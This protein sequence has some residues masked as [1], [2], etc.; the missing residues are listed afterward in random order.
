M[1]EGSRA[2]RHKLADKRLDLDLFIHLFCFISLLLIGADTWGVELLG[3]NFRV[4][5]I[6]LCIFALLLVFKGAY[7]LTAYG[8]ILAF[9]FF[10]FLSTLFAVSIFRGVLFFCSILYNV[11]F[12]FY[13]LASYVR[14][15]GFDMFLR[16]FRLTMKVQFFILLFQF[17]LKL[18][19]GY[20]LPFLPSYGE[21]MGIYRFQLWFYEPS[22]L[23]TYLMLWF[24]FSLIQ[25]LLGGKR[26]Y[27]T[28][29]LMCLIM[30]LISTSTSGFVGIALAVFVVY[31]M[32]LSRGITLKK[33]L[34]PLLLLVIFLVCLAAFPSVFEVF[35]GRLFDSSLDDASGGRI[36]GW[37]ETWRVFLENPFFGVGPGNYGIYLGQDEGYVPTNVSL[38]LLATLGIGGFVAFYGMTC[39]LCVR[40]VRLYRREK[41]KTSFLIMAFA[42]ALILFTIILQVNQG[43]LRLYQWM[44]F[45]VLYGALERERYLR[46]LRYTAA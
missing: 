22:Y 36:Q 40:A 33:L 13:G 45:G 26:E 9:V 46:R 7:R 28:D 10:S 19:T 30:F 29:V 37:A 38:E 41:T 43:Y 12:L 16:I 6:F 3:V 17:L 15:Y 21:Y 42:V 4:D 31:C 27:V 39:S 2:V 8:W 5:Q 25:L 24:T 34:F 18:V 32:W 35:L 14:H 23:A 1:T 11:L 44:C 20:E